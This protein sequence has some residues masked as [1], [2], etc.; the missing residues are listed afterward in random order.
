MGTERTSSLNL[1]YPPFKMMLVTAIQDA[2]SKGMYPLIFESW[3][4]N[5][6]QSFL[7]AQGRTAPGAIVTNASPGLSFHSYGLAVDL[8]FDSDPATERP[9]WTWK[10][11]YG[12]LSIIMTTYGLE[13]LDFEKAHFQ[14]RY[15]LTV[16][17]L[18][19]IAD[20]DGVLGVWKQLD[21]LQGAKK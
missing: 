4:S 3:R 16:K 8:V 11:D 18:K 21:K 20:T 7:Y 14:K 13:A 19:A 6:R 2:N 1:L 17:E 10:G 9:D 15:G 5:E 12:K